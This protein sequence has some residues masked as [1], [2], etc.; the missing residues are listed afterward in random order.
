MILSTLRGEDSAGVVVVPAKGQEPTIVKTVGTSF[1]LFQ[2]KA[3]TDIQVATKRALIGHTRKATVGGIRKA[4]AHPFQAGSIFGVHNGTLRNWRQ[5]PVDEEATDSITLYNCIE[6]E[7]LRETIEQTDGAYA[8]VFYD[9][10]DD[11]LNFLRNNERSLHYAFSKD[12]KKIYWASEPWMLHVALN[13]SAEDMADLS[14]KGEDP[15]YTLPVDEDTWFRIRISFGKN[16]IAFLDQTELKGNVKKPVKATF[17]Q[18]PNNSG[19]MGRP[20]RTP[21]DWEKDEKLETEKKSVTLLPNANPATTHSRVVSTAT[22]QSTQDSKKSESPTSQGSPAPRPT[23]SLVQD[24]RKSGSEQS[25]DDLNDPLPTFSNDTITGYNGRQLTEAGYKKTDEC[26][27][28]CQGE[29]SFAEAVNDL[30]IGKWISNESFLCSSCL[31]RL[32]GSC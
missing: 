2:M 3:Y 9:N 31:P 6:Q 7:G 1:D 15:C 32:D 23:L 24:S 19:Y 30:A 13:R 17:F 8:L 14:K 11:T 20:Y 25:T 5:L 26:C 27:S 21:F 28:Y 16:P 12:F 29:V 4:T 18:N 10:D 22:P